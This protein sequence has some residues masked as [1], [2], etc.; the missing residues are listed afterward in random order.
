[1]KISEEYRNRALA[2]EKGKEAKDYDIKCAWADAA[3]NG[4]PSPAELHKRLVKIAILKS[5]SKHLES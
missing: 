3:M 1:M 2:C 5:V 4:I